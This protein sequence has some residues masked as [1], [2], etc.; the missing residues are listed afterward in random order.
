MIQ[1]II[2][3]SLPAALW[4]FLM[5]DFVL[6]TIPVNMDTNTI[7]G[8][9]KFYFN[10]L[11]NGV[12]PLWE[13]FVALGRPFYALSICNLFN[14]I[15]Q[16]IPLLKILGVN[17]AHGFVIYMVMYFFLGC[18]G[19][20][21]LALEI[22]KEKT[23]AYL[24]Y[25]AIMF[26]S[27]GASMFTQFTFLE[28]V[29]PGIW[30]FVFLLRFSRQQS[31]GNFIGMAFSKML[32]LSSYLPFYFI[33][34]FLCF[35]LPFLIL[36]FKETKTFFINL[37]QFFLKNWRLAFFCFLGILASA[38]PLLAYKILDSSGEVVTPGRHCEYSSAE[39]CYERTMSNQGGMLV[40]EIT[41]AGT[42][43]ERLDLQYLFGNLDKISYGS[44]S[45]FFLP[46]LIPILIV[47]GIFLPLTR[48]TI[49]L[50]STVVLV[51]LIALGA[52]SGLLGFLYHHI[53]FFRYFRNLFFLGAFLVPII[54]LLACHQWQMLLNLKPQDETQRK[55]IIIVIL[56]LHI[57][58]GVFLQHY[59]GVPTI[60]Y[61][62]LAISAGAWIC[63][64]VLDKRLSMQLWAG[65]FSV[66]IM[67]EP[68]WVLHQYAGHAREFA[69]TLPS[70]HVKPTFQ[71]VRSMAPAVNPS[72]LYQFVHYEDFW[73]DMSMT[74]APPVVAYP[75]SVTRWTFDLAQH[76]SA[77]ILAN[78]AQYK[79]ILYDEVSSVG[80]PVQGPS[81][82]I[83]VEYFDVNSLRLHI[84]FSKPKL[85][86][87]NDSYTSSWKAAMDG[88]PTDL[89]R[90][91]EAFKGI[92]LPAGEHTVEFSYHPPG[93]SWVY[94]L[95]TG[96]L[97][98]FFILTIYSIR[99][100]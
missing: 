61:I 13:P 83:S 33:T 73:Y 92:K 95:A 74:D 29:V 54:I 57:A 76:T 94:V 62:T 8:V 2:G 58:T 39:Q 22:F 41:R 85:L 6:G 24:A 60:S 97:F 49:L 10:N 31:R 78:Y 69:T 17:Y 43:G 4:L 37:W 11:L 35:S 52:A 56:M 5:R 26:S 47:L 18:F 14:P 7:Y 77:Q 23:I 87:Y 27:F 64:F 100:A 86:V 42:L 44:D 25:V 96:V 80:Q 50:S 72:R 88:V 28:I 66:M 53:F 84:N 12:V 48:L 71:W 9:T 40:D 70:M 93:E 79:I 15:I 45:L 59:L 91:N 63:F 75:Q 32:L 67:L 46:V 89:I 65:I 82:E 16:I 21:C 90:A 99:Y 1:R 81:D 3:F 20:Y 19:F 55:F 30:L 34:V 51:G 68:A 98:F 38:G 36:Y